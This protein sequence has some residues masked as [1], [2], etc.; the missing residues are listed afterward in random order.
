MKEAFSKLT[1][2]QTAVL[3]EEF[4]I[5]DK[6]KSG[7]INRTEFA[8][9]M[10]SLDVYNSTEAEEAGINALFDTID[11]SGDDKIDLHEFLT[12]MAMSMYTDIT[13]EEL[14]ETFKIF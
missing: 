9:V 8:S 10:R 2:E 13:E 3:T 6:D 14:I 12:M 4:H 5:F 1:E 7:F 11:K